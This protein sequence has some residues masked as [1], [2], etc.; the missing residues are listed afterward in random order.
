MI[1]PLELHRLVVPAA[2]VLLAPDPSAELDT[3]IIFGET[4]EI[5]ERR[6]IWALVRAELDDKEGWIQAP[7]TLLTSIESVPVPTHRVTHS[8]AMVYREP[9]FRSAPVTV[10]SMNSL[11]AVGENQDS[12]RGEGNYTQVLGLVGEPQAWIPSDRICAKKNRNSLDFVEEAMKFLGVLYGWGFRDAS[13]GIDCSA[14]LQQ[15][16][17][18]CGVRCPRDCRPQSEELG[19]QVYSDVRRR[20]DLVFW[21]ERKGRHVVIMLDHRRCIHATIAPPYRGV[22]IQTLSDVILDQSCNDNGFPTVF[23]RFPDYQFA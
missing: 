8:R 5:L 1:Q 6:D 14:L 15:S 9:N 20:G 18:A 21:T 13:P 12:P 19:E 22:V 17:I 10:L 7:D 23:R 2:K 4:V 16:L 11:I 3:Q